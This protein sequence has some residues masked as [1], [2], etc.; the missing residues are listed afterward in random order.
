MMKK[1]ILLSLLVL[2]LGANLLAQTGLKAFM[3]K[4]NELTGWQAN[5]DLREYRGEEIIFA[6]NRERDLYHEFGFTGVLNSSFSNK[7]KESLKL[8][9]FR[10]KDVYATYGVYLHKIE[11]MEDKYS[12]G[13]EAYFDDNSLVFW[14]HH[15]VAVI[16]GDASDSVVAEGMK[17]LADIIDSRIKIQGR[18]PKISHSFRD[19]PGKITLLRGK[20]GL[21]NIYYFTSKDVFRIEEGYAIEKPGLT[22]ICLYYSDSFTSIRRFSDI[23]GV[24]SREE[25]FSGFTMIGHLAFQMYDS[26]GNDISVE[27][28]NNCLNIRI[29]KNVITTAELNSN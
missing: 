16:K 27:S 6:T 18:W 21:Q 24:L 5:N 4:E 10:M 3:P 13:K 25:R 8:E 14:K 22:D 17:M 26:E 15:Y 9:I 11:G 1:S 7:D 23:A 19:S 12:V 28:E 2:L 20:Y 29:Q